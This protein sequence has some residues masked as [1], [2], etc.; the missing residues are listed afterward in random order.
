MTLEEMPREAGTAIQA[1]KDALLD[2]PDDSSV[3]HTKL[4]SAPPKIVKAQGNYLTTSDGLEI[5]DAT[6]GAAVACIGHNQPRVKK[7]IMDQLDEVAYCYSP[8][9]TTSASEK[10]AKFLTDS[11]QG[12]MSKVFIVS[13]GTE[14]VE[15]A[16]KMARQYFTELPEP[17]LQRTRFIARHQSYH[18]NTL[19]ALSVG[20]HKARKTMYM[21]ILSDNVSHVSP[22]YA[23]RGQKDGEGVESYVKRLVD[24]LEAKF[25]AVGPGNVCAFIAETMSGMV[26][27]SQAS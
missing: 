21:P 2:K 4:T 16:L 10:L 23:Y 17:Q 24:E 5:F 25:Q 26:R 6:G 11:T 27:S 15:A 22:C 14:A 9:F 3:L 1:A 7:A 8:F 19:G 13:S 18:G 12:V 20:S